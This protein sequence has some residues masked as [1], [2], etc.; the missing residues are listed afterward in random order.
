MLIA[1]NEKG[2]LFLKE[3]TILNLDKVGKNPS[4]I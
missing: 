4:M 1:C 2:T 3:E